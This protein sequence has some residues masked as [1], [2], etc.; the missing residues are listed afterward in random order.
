MAWVA[1]LLQHFVERRRK[2]AEQTYSFVWMCPESRTH[3]RVACYFVFFAACGVDLKSVCVW[4]FW[5]AC[6]MSS[7]EDIIIKIQSKPILWMSAD[8]NFKNWVIKV[9]LY[10]ESA[11][12]LGIQGQFLY[13]QGGPKVCSLEL[14]LI[15]FPQ[16]FFAVSSE[17]TDFP[18]KIVKQKYLARNLW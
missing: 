18:K 9:K 10:R 2:C 7:F 5:S 4:A 8:P 13:I 17:N 6:E 1:A 16:K 14:T 11:K 12:K 15:R 3:R